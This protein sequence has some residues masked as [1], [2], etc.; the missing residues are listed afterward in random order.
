MAITWKERPDSRKWT[1]GKD[2]SFEMKYNVNGSSN[3][4]IILREA[5]NNVPARYHDLILINVSADPD[6]NTIDGSKNRGLWI[7]TASYK[8]PTISG[9]KQTFDTSGGT[10]H[11][12]Q[13]IRT[14]WSRA[15]DLKTNLLKKATDHQGAINADGKKVNGVDITVPVFTFTETYELGPHIMNTDYKITLFDVTGKINDRKFRGFAAEEVLFKGASGSL[16]SNGVYQV[17]FKFEAS[18]TLTNIQVGP[19]I[20]VPLKKGFDYMWVAYGKLPDMD[21][22]KLANPPE[23][24]YVEEIFYKADFAKL[25]I[26]TGLIPVPPT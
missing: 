16:D 19:H 8:S 10:F 12:T 21:T 15:V 7:V 6:P 11:V 14:L 23:E 2:S 13:S 5:R 3:D 1:S 22:G 17:E 24:V 18:P 9:V 20:I 4:Q 26:G 25:N